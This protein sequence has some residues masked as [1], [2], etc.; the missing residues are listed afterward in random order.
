MA[1]AQGA[2][3]QGRGQQLRRAGRARVPVHARVRVR[4]GEG[5]ECAAVAVVDLF[6]DV[7]G[8][9]IAEVGGTVGT[10]DVGV[11]TVVRAGRAQRVEVD[12]RRGFGAP[13]GCRR[14]HRAPHVHGAF[15]AV[16]RP[17]GEGQF[18]GVTG[19]REAHVDVARR[20]PDDH[21]ASPEDVPQGGGAVESGEPGRAARHLQADR[22]GQQPAP[23][24]DVVAHQGLVGPEGPAETDLVD[25]GFVGVDQRVEAGRHRRAEPVRA[26]PVTGG[27]PVALAGERVQRRG[28]AARGRSLGGDERV[29]VR[30]AVP[31]P[32][33]GEREG[34]T[35]LLR[36]RGPG[37]VGREEQA[38]ARRAVLVGAQGAD[39]RGAVLGDHGE[40]FLH[41][42]TPALERVGEVQGADV[43]AFGEVGEAARVHAQPF[44]VACRERED[45]RLSEALPGDGLGGTLGAAQVL[46]DHQVGVGAARAEGAEP[47][48]AGL[49]AERALGPGPCGRLPLHPEGGSA[50]VDVGVELLG[51]QRGHQAP[52]LELEQ[53]LGE[54]GDPGGR[55][56]VPDV[57]LD[58][59]DGP[60]LLPPRGGAE[61]LGESGDLDRV[62]QGGAGAVGLHVTDVGRA[63][64]RAVQCAAHGV[65]LRVRAGH[66][67]TVRTAAV[68]DRVAADH[69]VDVVAVALGGGQRLQQH[70]ADALAR[71]V[72]GS[73]G[74]EGTAP[75]VGG[76]EAALAE[77][78]VLVRV[79]GEVHAARDGH[80]AL[81]RAQA[82]A[83]QVD[84]RQGRRAHG[85]E[86]EA[87]PG[88]AQG[89]GDAVGDRGERR[90]GDADAAALR[91]GGAVQLVLA[92]HHADE[93]ADAAPGQLVPA[94]SGVLQDVPGVLE[95][96][97]LLR[98]HQ[99]GL[100]GR[101]AEEERVEAVDVV[102]ETAPLG[103][104][105]ARRRGVRV[106]VAVVVPAVRGDLR[107]A[108][109]ARGEVLPERF[110]VVGHGVAPGEPDDG[111]GTVVA[112]SRGG[113][114]GV[115]GRRPGRPHHGGGGTRGHG[116]GSGLPRARQFA[117]ACGVLRR[118][119]ARELRQRRVLEEQRLGQVVEVPFQ[120]GVELG[121][122][123]RVDAV[124]VEGHL[125]VDLGR[126]ELGA[127]GE[128]LTQEGA[129]PFRQ[130]R[131]GRLRAGRSPGRG[132]PRV[133]RHGSGCE[134]RGH[135]VGV[136]VADEDRAVVPAQCLVEGGEARGG[137]HGGQA[138][139]VPHG[140]YGVLVLAHPAV[141]PQR[142]GQGQGA[143][144]AQAR[145]GQGPAALGEGVEEGVGVRVV[146]L[147]GVAEDTGD[148]READE[149]VQRVVGGEPVQVDGSPRLG[150][151]DL[152]ELLPGLVEEVGVAQGAR[153]VDHPA[154]RPVVGAD[155]V[156]QGAQLVLVGHVRAPEGD[157]VSGRAERLDAPLGLGPRVGP[158]GQDEGRGL[159]AAREVLGDGQPETPGAT[160][161][162]AGA[163]PGGHGAALSVGGRVQA[164]EPAYVADAAG[165]PR[166]GLA[167]AR[168]GQFGHEGARRRGRGVQADEAEG[169]T[170]VLQR[171]GAGEARE[172]GRGGVRAVRVGAVGDQQGRARAAP[173]REEGLGQR[174][175][176]VR[177]VVEQG[178]RERVRGVARGAPRVEHGG[179]CA[180]RRGEAVE[181]R[182]EVGLAAR[183]HG[184]VPA[185]GLGELRA[186]GDQDDLGVRVTG[187]AQGVDEFGAGRGAVREQ[188]V[189]A[190]GGRGR[191]P[192]RGHGLPLAA[193]Q[194]GPGLSVFGSQRTYGQVTQPD[195]RRSP[196][197]EDVDVGLG[198]L[199]PRAVRG[200][201]DVDEA[202]RGQRP[203]HLHLADRQRQIRGA[204]V[205]T[206]GEQT[207]HGVQGSVEQR[208]VQGEAPDGVVRARPFTGLGV[209][210]GEFEDAEGLRVAS[211][212]LAQGPHRRAVVEPALPQQG[213]QLGRVEQVR[214]APG[215]Y[216]R[217]DGGR[218]VALAARREFA[219]REDVGSAR[220]VARAT[221]DGEP[222]A[223][224]VRGEPDVDR[225]RPAREGQGPLEGDPAQRDTARAHP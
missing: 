216:G 32:A 74:A 53:H 225:A 88:Q 41:H 97:A 27:H 218:A 142:P 49:W 15:G 177:A 198:L 83:G 109:A 56:E 173:A 120:L 130:V 155:G 106:E 211:A 175:D 116:C 143:A 118:E 112:G 82:L 178:G 117:E 150:G 36:P 123:Q 148:G 157:V 107:D 38:G 188:E 124:A 165:V 89:V 91:V 23:L 133:P 80:L 54:P 184:E 125:Q 34:R 161:D 99:L 78:D 149:E 60:A 84:R 194:R 197:V 170:R 208:G 87:R 16:R 179:G 185:V 101:D 128:Q 72:P 168:R 191:L 213:V 30:R 21:R 147:S 160:G 33:R 114:R 214:T 10:L 111:H 13:S 115:R 55:F 108:V 158:A 204:V 39:E 43:V 20:V 75:A 195:E 6:D 202:A 98:V 102:Q 28:D 217:V 37:R 164:P 70:R 47:G 222:R 79:H 19:A 210:V 76:D 25:G 205:L 73:S 135:A 200:Q 153:R 201:R 18:G 187:G 186:G 219:S 159:G 212:Q 66:G 156:E 127:P 206:G 68:V 154:Q 26:R 146:A 215:E 7:E 172:G 207:D 96:E 17:D 61:D 3:E 199:L 57:R 14:G 131:V 24:D 152:G 52:V 134:R 151:D 51:V 90:A 138:E 93:D 169:Q 65:G 11:V 77:E 119:V 203:E 69:A 209:R 141:P 171:G 113:R 196:G 1:G 104:G 35:V 180:V 182:G 64:A 224:A 71:H 5:D 12:G 167:V 92:V 48:A 46:L 145:V 220:A 95:E 105:A 122:D 2:V 121:D 45:E 137:G 63:E 31:R 190:G 9:S 163:A 174:E 67:V 140:P 86:R 8:P 176:A 129:R 29:P 193:E 136:A 192:C 189:R 62:A 59:A 181:E 85:V 139:A 144:G 110:E 44:R 58:R 223:V 42:L 50:E 166:L 94:V 183:V 221:G 100:A 162:Q 40:A 4:Q 81:P 22:A 132:G 103:R 126:V